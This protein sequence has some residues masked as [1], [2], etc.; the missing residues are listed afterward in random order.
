MTVSSDLS[1][2]VDMPADIVVHAHSAR[3][4]PVQERCHRALVEWRPPSAVDLLPEPGALAQFPSVEIQ[5]SGNS[6]RFA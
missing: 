6:R 4:R 1:S 3:L 2:F 5:A